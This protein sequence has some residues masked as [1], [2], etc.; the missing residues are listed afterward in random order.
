[1]VSLSNHEVGHAEAGRH[2]TAPFDRLRV[3]ATEAARE[4]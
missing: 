1:M 3:R 2:E 4:V